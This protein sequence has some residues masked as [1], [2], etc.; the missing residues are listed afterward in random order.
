MAGLKQF[1]INIY[2]GNLIIASKIFE[3]H[4]CKLDLVFISLNQHNLKI[5]T[6]K[7]QLAQQ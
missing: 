3:D 1:I 2:I 7:C 5:N 4:F 6:F